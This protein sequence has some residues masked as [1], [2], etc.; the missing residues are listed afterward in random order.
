[1][2][3]TD[4]PKF[5]IYLEPIEG[6]DGENAVFLKWTSNDVMSFS[7]EVGFLNAKDFGEFAM[8]AVKFAIVN[9]ILPPSQLK[10]L[11]DDIIS[12]TGI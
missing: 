8:D 3:P 2:R 4:K 5:D 11:N 6:E 7:N 12:I 9:N 1:M 10:E